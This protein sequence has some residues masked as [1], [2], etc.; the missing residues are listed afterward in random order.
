MRQLVAHQSKDSAIGDAG[1]QEWETETVE[2][3]TERVSLKE[4]RCTLI[5]SR[6]FVKCLTEFSLCT[7]R[8]LRG[9][10]CLHQEKASN[11]LPNTLRC[12]IKCIHNLKRKDRTIR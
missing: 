11:W 1:S 9:E 5:K 3:E 12:Y 2:F 7:V 8:Y 6:P 10:P 4:N